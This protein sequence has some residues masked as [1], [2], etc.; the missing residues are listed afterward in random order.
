[1]D[2]LDLSQTVIGPSSCASTALADN[3]GTYTT[4]PSKFTSARV[5]NIFGQASAIFILWSHTVS[6]RAGSISPKESGVIINDATREPAKAATVA[7]ELPTPT[8]NPV[9]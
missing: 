1:M 6:T 8:N 7:N 2:L 4:R 3:N 9:L 5:L